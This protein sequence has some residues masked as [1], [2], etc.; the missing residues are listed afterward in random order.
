MKALNVYFILSLYSVAGSA[1]DA[2]KD[3]SP[4]Q[5]AIESIVQAN[6]DLKRNELPRTPGQNFSAGGLV[7]RDGKSCI[8]PRC[9]TNP[10]RKIENQGLNSSTSGK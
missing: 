7:G 1:G 8:G 5:Q 10:E 2:V 9:P 6:D 3:R 4:A